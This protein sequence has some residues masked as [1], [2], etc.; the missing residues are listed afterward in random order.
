MLCNKNRVSPHRG[1]F[2]VIDWKRCAQ[3]LPEDLLCLDADLIEAFFSN[4][5]LFPFTEMK[6]HPEPGAGKFFFQYRI[7]DHDLIFFCGA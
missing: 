1:L 3:T 6:T 7:S 4:V 2:A 5:L